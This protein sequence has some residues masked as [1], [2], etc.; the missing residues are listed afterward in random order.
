[1]IGPFWYL[2]N[3]TYID[4][5]ALVATLAEYQKEPDAYALQA[6]NRFVRYLKGSASYGARY[7]PTGPEINGF[8][9]ADFAGDQSDR[10]T[11]TGYFIKL[12]SSP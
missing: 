3:R 12:S 7:Y 5:L 8:V 4:V 9:D 10:K 6:A 1:M 2:D 11:M